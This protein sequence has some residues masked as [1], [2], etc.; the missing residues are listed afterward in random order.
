[1]PLGGHLT[2]PVTAYWV[3]EVWGR[4]RFQT[5]VE[6]HSARGAPEAGAEPAVFE[7]HYVIGDPTTSPSLAY[8]ATDSGPIDDLVVVS[9]PA[10][11]AAAVQIRQRMR[12]DGA[13]LSDPV[14]WPSRS[15]RRPDGSV[16]TLTRLLFD[17]ARQGQYALELPDS[18]VSFASPDLDWEEAVR[19]AESV[20]TVS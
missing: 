7:A 3:G 4:R 1:V 12:K 19:L 18:L 14:A 8:P 9:R 20:V 16:A 13:S 11:S 5:G 15:I 2:L 10:D 6:I 17:D